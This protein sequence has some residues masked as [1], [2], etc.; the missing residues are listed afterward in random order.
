M[1]REKGRERREREGREEGTGRGPQFKKNDP[2]PVIRWLVT[3]LALPSTKVGI[4]Q[5]QLGTYAR[6]RAYSYVHLR[7]VNAA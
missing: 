7:S 6:S 3:G 5:L 4:G 1:G 2:S